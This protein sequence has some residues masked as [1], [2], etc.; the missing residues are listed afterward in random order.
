MKANAI[1]LSNKNYFDNSKKEGG[2]RQCTFEYL[3]VLKII[4]NVNIFEVDYK[5]DFVYRLRV[6]LGLNVYNDYRPLFYKKNLI[7]FIRLHNANIVF[8]NLSNTAPFAT[9]IKNE[10]GKDVKVVLCSHGNE[11]G[12][13]LHETVKFRGKLSVIKKVFCSI[14]LGRMLQKESLLRQTAIDAVLTV[15]EIEEAIEKWLGSTKVEM[16]PRL[17]EFNKLNLTP[18]LGRVGFMGDLSH[19]PNFYG[20]DEVC[21]SIEKSNKSTN[22]QVH[23]VGSP[24]P[25]GESFSNRYSFVNYV[26]Y[27]DEERLIKEVSTWTLFLNPVFYCSR[28]VSTKLAK[29]ISWN[30]PVITTSIGCRGYFW[31]DGSLI[32]AESPQEFCCQIINLSNDMSEIKNARKELDKIRSSSFSLQEISSRLEIFLKKI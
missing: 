29:A 15:S 4:Y 2:V 12:D 19:P 6:K 21:K 8:L 23:I 28:G 9:L 16:I 17:I 20:I 32:I 25:I 7:D 11:S 24:S 30:I 27:L 14:T 5:I 18:V 31:N 10:F 26:G 1:F 13:F 22:I 3:S